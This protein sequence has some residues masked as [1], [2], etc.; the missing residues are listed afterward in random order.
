MRIIW[1]IGALLNTTAMFAIWAAESAMGDEVLA[2]DVPGQNMAAALEELSVET[3][4]SIAANKA[5]LRGIESTAVR[6]TM[7]VQEA[8]RTMLTDT[9]LAA[10]KMPD[11]GFV[12]AL[13][14]DRNVV[15]QD[16]DDEPF[17]LGTLLLRGDRSL[18]SEFDSSA[19]VSV[20]TSEDLQRTPSVRTIEDVLNRT[21]N[22]SE[23]PGNLNGVS[24]RGVDSA[25][26]TGGA[27]AFSGGFRPR[28]SVVVDGRTLS[29]FEATASVTSLYDI[30]QVEVFRGPQTASQGVNAIAGS[31]YIFTRDPTFFS[32]SGVQLELGERNAVG[33]AGFVSGPIFEDQLAFRLTGEFSEEDFFLNFG[34]DVFPDANSLINRT[35]RGKLLWEPRSVQGFSALITLSYT[36]D[37]QPRN[38]IAIPPYEDLIARDAN[39]PGLF[40]QES[41]GTILEL[42]YDFASALSLSSVTTF[43]DYD[44]RLASEGAGTPDLSIGTFDGKEWSNETILR[45][46]ERTDQLSGLVGFRYSDSS[47]TDNVAIFAP[48]FP[49]QTLA[50]D[51]TSLGIFGEL[52][53]RV[54]EKLNLTGGLRYQEDSQE[55]Q[56]AFIFVP[57]DYNETFAELLPKFEVAYDASETTRYGLSVSKGFNP[58]GFTVDLARGQLDTYDEETVWNYELFYRASALDGRLNLGAN[59]FFSD[60]SGFQRRTVTGFDPGTGLPLASF[61]NVDAESY[62][63]EIDFDYQVS[64]QLSVYGGLGL[65]ETSFSEVVSPGVTEDFEFAQAPN[66]SGSIGLD[67]RPIDNLTI[68]GQMRFTDSYFSDDAN[69]AVDKISSFMI[70]DLSARYEFE[71]GATVYGF[72]TNVFDEGT[73]TTQFTSALGTFGTVIE[74]R[75]FGFGLE[76]I[77]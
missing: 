47:Q 33:I 5:F 52:T 65:L 26:P 54:T 35:L 15:S 58:G 42:N 14:L 32:E 19:S 9:K 24:I 17:D 59:L 29:Q 74:P 76:M 48:A 55:R 51:K 1:R 70:A 34:T 71:N 75:T 72:I 30:D 77:F 62:G 68:S 8:L 56:G 20:T 25:G 61:E 16:A 31:T 4:Q 18:L 10:E 38:I 44:I 63:L 66:Y 73:A 53:Y 7:S 39:D 46:G 23:D 57:V 69:S 60:W 43:S 28:A 49:A 50:D 64:N 3:G 67:Y 40:E 13:S 12:V 37:S 2:I 11:G 22:I 36:D 21:P 27:G 6:G 41:L 45:F